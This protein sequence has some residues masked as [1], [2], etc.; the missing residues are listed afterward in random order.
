MTTATPPVAAPAV[1]WTLERGATL[2][3]DGAVHFSVW[4]PH[5]SAA[6]VR[7]QSGPAAGEHPLVRANGTPGLLS[8]RVPDVGA[9]ADY[10][11]LLTGADGETRELPDPVS[12]WQPHG[13]HGASRVVDPAAHAW[14]DAAWRGLALA[15][16]VIYEL[17]VG[18]FTDEGTFD[19]AAADLPRLRELGVTAVELM[20]VAEFPGRRNWGY[21]GVHLYASHSAYG[22]PDG[23]R[24][25]VDAAHA[26]GI[27]V[28]LDVVY[29]HVGP[30][31]NYL[32]A[33][34]P[35]FTD[36]YRTPW[37]RAVNYD[38]PDSDEV[39]RWVV[40]NARYWVREFHVDGLRLDAV[41]GI[42]DLGASHVLREIGEAARAEGA[43]AGRTVVV[44]AESDQNDPRVVR[45]AAE[46][47]L[48][49]DAQWADDFHHAVHA[50]LTGE[51][52]GYYEDF[53]DVG[54]I[55][56]ALREPF[57]FDGG[58][59][60]HRR[61]KHGG[62]SAGLA[63]E[64]FVV[65]IQNHDQ[66]GNRATGD[67]LSVLLE[68]EALRLAA[69]LLLLSPYV[70]LL[71]MGEEYGETN[72]FLYF[73][74]HGDEQLVEAVRTGRREEFAAFAWEGEVPDPQAE[75]SFRRSRL[76]RA[77]LADPRH[78]AIQQLYRDL[79][80]LRREEP[81]LRPGAAPHRVS[82]LAD[83]DGGWITLL[84]GDGADALLAIFNCS[85]MERRVPLPASAAGGWALR[86]TTDG[87]GYGGRGRVP[88]SL[89]GG[90]GSEDG[91]GPRRLLVSQAEATM[92]PWTAAVYHRQ[93]RGA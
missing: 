13:V 49:M 84:R 30:E 6:R 26:L 54:R 81:V 31:G 4:A 82:H 87:E 72:P 71:F 11:Y 37:G 85:A 7:I 47:G 90:V 24:R 64:R 21:D 55:A 28:V 60:P 22:G 14:G 67:R 75:E 61:R 1:G 48:A 27:A 42:F 36:R 77:R 8:A 33:F 88:D 51:R 57:V 25:F 34:G 62:P 86:L 45:G 53:G 23:L 43:A 50:A 32:D 58:Y 10:V 16:Y 17:H 73:V 39:R 70:P 18:T 69:A 83:S 5:A 29:N 2:L 92:P 68:P 63:R 74:S 38:G 66:V 12:R 19:A 40:D 3:P 20:P 59:S 9:G 93:A 41:H 65:A 52:R 79:L 78:A 44:I 15:D 91:E 80:A 46:G 56:A 89:G 76:D 35:Y